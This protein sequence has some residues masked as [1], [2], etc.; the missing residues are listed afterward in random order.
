[1]TDQ[2]RSHLTIDIAVAR[3]LLDEVERM[4]VP[5]HRVMAQLAEELGRVASNLAA[6]VEP[7]SGVRLRSTA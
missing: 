6:H 4:T 7:N 3:A 5:D 2:D 1:M